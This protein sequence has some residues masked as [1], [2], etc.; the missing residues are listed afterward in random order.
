MAKE[1]RLSPQVVNKL[2]MA[3]KNNLNL[4]SELVEK[5]DGGK[6]RRD[7]IAETVNELNDEN[8][9]IDNAD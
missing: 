3:V 8:A 7:R 4:I 5:R 9:I 2:C 1:F 6:D